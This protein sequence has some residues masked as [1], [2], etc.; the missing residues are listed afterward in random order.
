MRG[1]KVY[2]VDT[3]A[4]PVPASGR[5]DF[6]AIYLLTGQHRLPGADREIA[7]DGT[8]LLFG[9]P[10][11]LRTSE[12]V[13]T[14]QT[15]YACVFTQ[16]F[17]QENGHTGIGEQWALFHG[18]AAYVFSLHDEQA[19]YLTTVFEKMLAEQQTTYLFKR[20]LLGS[21][22]QLVIHEALRLRAPKRFFRYYCQ[23]IH[24]TGVPVGSWG[25]RQR[26]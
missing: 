26:R 9:K 22:L 14:H 2:R 24:S 20:E 1:F 12:G 17:V 3:A 6:Y 13:T 11:K 8:C 10:Y 16:E 7:L 15:G 18:T 25:R 23:P 19:A 5:R 4:G 21:Y